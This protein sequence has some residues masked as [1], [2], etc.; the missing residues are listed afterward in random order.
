MVTPTIGSNN[1]TSLSKTE[2]QELSLLLGADDFSIGKYLNKALNV[3]SKQ[4]EVK[5]KEI[6]EADLEK[7][8]RRM[9]EIALS[10]Q[11]E[12][13][14]CH[15]EIG[16]IGAELQAILPRCAADINRLDAGL[17]GMKQD[18]SNLMGIDQMKKNLATATTITKGASTI[19]DVNTM[20][21]LSTLHSLQT[22]LEFTKGILQATSHWD[23]TLSSIPSLLSEQKLSQAVTALT[24]LQQGA[25]A[26]RGM[27]GK[28][29][30]EQ[31]V[32]KF[33]TQ[34][35]TL[36]KPQLLHAFANI[37]NR[38]NLLHQT[39]EMY[40]QLNNTSDFL[41]EYVKNRPATLQ[42][43]WFSYAPSVS[44]VAQQTRT[45]TAVGSSSIISSTNKPSFNEFLSQWYDSILALLAEE[46]RR[47]QTVFKEKAPYVTAS[48]LR[49]TFRPL[50]PSFET[51]LNSICSAKSSV[52]SSEGSFTDIYKA[53]E[54]TLTFLSMAYDQISSSSSSKSNTKSHS[55]L[56]EEIYFTIVSPFLTHQL[57]YAILEYNNIQL[58][59]GKLANDIQTAVRSLTNSANSNSLTLLENSIE[60]LDELAVSIFPM[61]QGKA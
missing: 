42:K 51:R 44:A 25:R 26:L 12:T 20:K 7:V 61:A 3:S 1:L 50:L 41:E 2:L 18:V 31:T 56:I 6:K 54:Q 11:L 15:D 47:T 43:G 29:Q 60:K 22:N 17:H 55:E 46:R 58:Q 52:A 40:Q 21:T 9:H 10:L 24:H 49:E 45:T 35:E 16:R 13:Q 57:Q 19:S 28:D 32:Q 4:E 14:S 34:I 5:E 23:S 27:P 8:E 30:R 37:E 59:Q 36:L 53:Y 48:I 39:Y 33:K 38:V